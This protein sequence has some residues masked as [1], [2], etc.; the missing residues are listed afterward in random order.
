MQPSPLSTT[1]LWHIGRAVRRGR[2]EQS[3]FF[4]RE[5]AFL[6]NVEAN[7]DNS[8]DDQTNISWVRELIGAMA[9]YS[10]GNRYLNF[11]GFHEEGPA[12]IRRILARYCKPTR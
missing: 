1:A 11:A 4:G 12:M 2:S 8:G 10:D 6:L 9:P 3:A 7:W 5:A